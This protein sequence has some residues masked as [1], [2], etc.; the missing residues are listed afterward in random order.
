MLD[1]LDTLE[2]NSKLLENTVKSK[3]IWDIFPHLKCPLI[4]MCLSVNEQ[5]RILKK[6]GLPLKKKT[7]YYI[8]NL[9]MTYV[10]KKNSVSVK[11]DQY[12]RHK[13]RKSISKFADIKEKQLKKEW[14]AKLSSGKVEEILYAI[15]LR[16]D[17]SDE[18][19][20]YVYGEVHMMCHANVDDVM[21][22]RRSLELELHVNQKLAGLLNREKARIKQLKQKNERLSNELKEAKFSIKTAKKQQNNKPVAINN[23]L[24]L[25]NAENRE[26][27]DKVSE[28]ET[29]SLYI[30]EEV[31]LLERQ[32]RRTQIKMF[33]LQSINNQLTDEINIF[34]SQN[35]TFSNFKEKCNGVCNGKCSE[36]CQTCTEF[37]TCSKRILLVGGITK[38]KQ[39]YR[40]LVESNGYELD[41]HDGYMKNGHKNLESRVLKSDLIIC[42]VNCNSHGACN[43]IKKLCK[44]HNKSI[45][46]LPNSSLSSVSSALVETFPRLN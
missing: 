27:K 32:K 44:K 20:M 42:P 19:I 9:I 25:L 37:Q 15:A 11:T 33:E 39:F 8:H 35:S 2:S 23:D 45:K 24:K 13:Y 21:K 5:K 43:R 29:Q 22:S 28:L 10:D 18:F 6:A 12:L 31:N 34:I 14:E 46:I 41:Y 17:I 38:M 40:S 7:P 30:S 4:G 26:L 36:K 1:T 3:P 16:S